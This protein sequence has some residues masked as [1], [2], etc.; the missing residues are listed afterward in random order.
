MQFVMQHE[1][2]TKA[3]RWLDMP[4]NAAHNAVQKQDRRDFLG[5]YKGGY[6]RRV[7]A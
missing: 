3:V 1:S 2:S 7:M 6:C 5:Y 4:F